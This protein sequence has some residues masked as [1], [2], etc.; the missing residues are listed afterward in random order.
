MKQLF[1]DVIEDEVKKAISE[2]SNKISLNFFNN[3][4][5]ANFDKEKELA[6]LQIEKTALVQINSILGPV[7]KKYKEE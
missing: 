4:C 5:N 7:F 2:Y 1:I 6:I 3:C